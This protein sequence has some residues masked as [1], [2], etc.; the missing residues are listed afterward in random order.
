LVVLVAGIGALSTATRLPPTRTAGAHGQS[1]IVGRY[2][3]RTVNGQ[4]LPVTLP[5][6]EPKN[7]IQVTDG[8]LELNADGSFLCRTLATAVSFGLKEPFADTLLGAYTIVSPGSIQ[9]N[10]KG[11][12]PDTIAATGYQLTWTHPVRTTFTGAFLYSK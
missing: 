10:H 3:L 1:S 9:L 7:T 6:L 2:I 12:H 4:R 11:L 8:V 5:G